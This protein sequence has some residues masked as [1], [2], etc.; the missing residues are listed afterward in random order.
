VKPWLHVADDGSLAVDLR[1][2]YASPEGRAALRAGAIECGLDPDHP[3]AAAQLAEIVERM[4][5]EPSC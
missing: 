5:E 1:A 3:D 2:F 4:L